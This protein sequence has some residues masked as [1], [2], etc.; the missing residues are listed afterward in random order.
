MFSM[1]RPYFPRRS[2]TIGISTMLKSYDCHI[3]TSSG[4]VTR[5]FP[6]TIPNPERWTWDEKRQAQQE[7]EL[8]IYS[9]HLDKTHLAHVMPVPLL[10]ATSW[11]VPPTTSVPPLIVANYFDWVQFGGQRKYS[12][13]FY[14]FTHKQLK[15]GYTYV[16]N[17]V[18]G[19]DQRTIEIGLL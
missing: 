15:F 5:P 17:Q 19:Y 8:W 10:V 3:V 18:K 6:D 14:L 11:L 2:I 1:S 9:K 16:P 7:G 13:C 12:V 4:F